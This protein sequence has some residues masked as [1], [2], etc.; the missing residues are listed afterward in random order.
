MKF[1]VP[2]ILMLTYVLVHWG[3]LLCHRVLLHEVVG[4]GAVSEDD[5]G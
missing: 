2:A 5:R 3:S 4:S 1:A